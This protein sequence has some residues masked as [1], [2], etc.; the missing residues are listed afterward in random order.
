[1]SK[2][3]VLTLVDEMTLGASTGSPVVSSYYDRVVED[4]ARFPWLTTASL[5]PITASTGSYQLSNGQSKIVAMFYD[6]RQLGRLTLAEV[7]SLNRTWR[8]EQGDPHSYVEEGEPVKTFRLYPSPLL[9]SKPQSF[10]N[11]APLGQDFPPYTILVIH[12]GTRTDLPTWLEL[13]V[14]LEVAAR[15][16]ERESSHRDLEWSKQARE[17]SGLLFAMVGER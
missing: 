2:T 9:S 1:M 16:M 6:H 4:L 14:A 5:I 3:T 7:E 11:L 17:L 10:P 13:P 15:E 8:N 12:T